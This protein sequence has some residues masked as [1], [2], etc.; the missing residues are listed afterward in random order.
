MASFLVV[1]TRIAAIAAASAASAAASAASAASHLP[2]LP[3]A[4]RRVLPAASP[5]RDPIEPFGPLS[6]GAFSGAPIPFHPDPL[7]RYVSINPL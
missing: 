6:G 3:P 5:L 7:A 1:V 4:E 2:P